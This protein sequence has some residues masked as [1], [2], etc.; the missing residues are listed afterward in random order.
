MLFLGRVAGVVIARLPIFVSRMGK[1]TPRPEV[2]AGKGTAVL[3]VLADKTEHI[4]IIV[5]GKLLCCYF[6]NT[7]YHPNHM[8]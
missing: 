1:A 6:K 4:V 5:I 7:V 3:P 2:A 8:H